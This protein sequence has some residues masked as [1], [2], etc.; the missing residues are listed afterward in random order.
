MWH[1][2]FARSY[3]RATHLGLG[4]CTSSSCLFPRIVTAIAPP[5]L[6]LLRPIAKLIPRLHIYVCVISDPAFL[7]PFPLF[8]SLINYRVIYIYISRGRSGRYPLPKIAVQFDDAWRDLC[9]WSVDDF[10]VHIQRN[11][12][13]KPMNCGV[14][15]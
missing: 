15:M 13:V 12:L 7:S 2:F 4:A 14:Q 5:S 1:P 10:R 8:Y 6:H 11:R 3:V 9:A